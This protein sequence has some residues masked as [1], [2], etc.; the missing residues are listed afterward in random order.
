M[1]ENECQL[2]IGLTPTQEK[3]VLAILNTR[4]LQEAANQ[5]GVAYITLRRWTKQPGFIA[6]FHQLRRELAAQAVSRAQ[7]SIGIGLDVLVKLATDE[8][9]PP[10]VRLGAAWK[11]VEFG[12]RAAED[13]SLRD[14][15]ARL[16]A[17]V[18]E[19]PAELASGEGSEE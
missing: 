12:L 9:T 19:R 11:L 14:Q 5:C 6:R 2:E 16:E 18:S 3:A 4:T 8:T 7:A 10:P 17:M 1:N 13:D 15:V